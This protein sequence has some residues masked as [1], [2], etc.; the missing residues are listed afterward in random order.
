MKEKVVVGLSG[1]VDSAVAAYLLREQGY[2]VIGATMQFWQSDENEKEMESIEDA[3][4]IA[5]YLG[6]SHVIMNFKKDFKEHVISY[7]VNEYTNGRTP[8]PCVVCNRHVKW[9]SLLSKSRE[10][11]AN[12]IATGHYARIEQLENGRYVLKRAETSAKDQTYALFNLTQDQLAS[13]RMPI[14]NY[15]KEEVREIAAKLQIPVANKPDSQEICFIPDHDYA[16]YIQRIVGTDAIGIG[17][18]VLED[19]TVLGQ[20]KGIIHYTI[21]QRKGLDL[22][23]GYPVFVV[24]IRPDTKEVVIGTNEKV[25]ATQLHCHKMNFMAMEAL[26]SPRTVLAKIRYNHQGTKCLIERVGEDEVKC[27]FEESVRAVTKGQAVVFYEEDYV[28]GGGIIL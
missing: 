18:F 26:D 20:H 23:M 17:N 4:K 10:L 28:V 24:D 2:E 8:N 7:F 15:H 1:G 13:T 11:G 6:I 19:G 14:G 12:Y 5:D 9:Q 25:F 16:G 3:K 27:T 22:A 21:G